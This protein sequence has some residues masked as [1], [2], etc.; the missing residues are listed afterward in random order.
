MQHVLQ[1]VQ[2]CMKPPEIKPSGYYCF[3]D[4]GL[5]YNQQMDETNRN[6]VKTPRD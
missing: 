1:V 3:M 6:G 4:C 2:L 5:R